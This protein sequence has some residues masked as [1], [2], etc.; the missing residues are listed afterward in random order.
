MPQSLP[1]V[2]ESDAA[3]NFPSDVQWMARDRADELE[4]QSKLLRNLE[5]DD[6]IEHLKRSLR[7]LDTRDQ[8]RYCLEVCHGFLLTSEGF[9]VKTEEKDGM[10]RWAYRFPATTECKVFPSTQ[11]KSDLEKIASADPD[12]I[13]KRLGANVYWRDCVEWGCICSD[14]ACND[15]EMAWVPCCWPFTIPATIIG[16]VLNCIFGISYGDPR[17]F[18]KK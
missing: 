14:A 15:C 4:R 3:T 6:V 12:V 11:M 2:E 9:R 10:C 18:S 17:D 13:K 16:R 1:F 8:T 5:K 7:A